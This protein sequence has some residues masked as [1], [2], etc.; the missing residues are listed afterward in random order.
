LQISGQAGAGGSLVRPSNWPLGAERRQFPALEIF[1]VTNKDLI[2][3]MGDAVKARPNLWPLAGS[4][5]AGM[6]WNDGKDFGLLPKQSLHCRS[7][8]AI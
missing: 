8:G 3:K 1:I 7:H 2:P 5:H 4:D 6:P